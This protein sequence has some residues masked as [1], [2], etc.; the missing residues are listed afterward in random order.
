MMERR[1]AGA[2]VQTIFV[3]DR[4]GG[5]W[6]PPPHLAHRPVTFEGNTGARISGTWFPAQRP[7]GAVVLAHPDKRYASHWFVKEGYVELLLSEGY[8]V[9][10]F[11]F[12][13]YGESRGPATYYHEDVLAAAR[14][15]QHWA[16][17]FPVHVLGVSMGAFAAA[18]ASPKLD[19]VRSM[20]LESPYP[21]FNAWYG[22]GPALYTM[23]LFD[24]MFP[25]TS[26]SIQA[27]RNLARAAPERILVAYSPRDDV[28]PPELSKQVAAVNPRATLHEVDAPHLGFLQDKRYVD[29]LLATLSS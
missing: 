11:D 20:V 18:N 8:D 10:T 29:A 26:R 27:D 22:R 2:L 17:G 15:A 16:G 25:R 9:L 4:R 6:L 13:G 5:P 12:V 28:T 19:F 14:F 23:K 1:L 7:R 3:R 21:S 24:A